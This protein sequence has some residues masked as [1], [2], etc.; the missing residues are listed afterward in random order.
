MNQPCVY[1]CPHPES[2]SHV[3]P[4]PALRVIPVHRLRV[5]CQNWL[6]MRYL[7][8]NVNLWFVLSA[9]GV[10]KEELSFPVSRS[11]CV[12]PFTSLTYKW[13]LRWEIEV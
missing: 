12:L 8:Q 4:I 11:L 10:N 13:L 6:L 1:V 2:P 9:V 3:P 5:P 7:W